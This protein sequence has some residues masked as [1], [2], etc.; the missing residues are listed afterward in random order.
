MCRRHPDGNGDWNVDSDGNGNGNG[1]RIC[2]MYTCGD[3]RGVV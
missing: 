2:N 3:T 1:N